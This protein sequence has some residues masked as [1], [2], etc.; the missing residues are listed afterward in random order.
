VITGRLRTGSE[1]L[2]LRLRV[3][4][5]ATNREKLSDFPYSISGL[6]TH[7]MG[8]KSCMKGGEIRLPTCVHCHVANSTLLWLLCQQSPAP[9]RRHRARRDRARRPRM[10]SHLSRALPGDCAPA[11]S[12]RG[13]FCGVPILPP[14]GGGEPHPAPAAVESVPRVC[15]HGRARHARAVLLALLRPFSRWRLLLPQQDPAPML[16][17]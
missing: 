16:G 12:D 10:S 5:G 7:S 11:K 2:S 13:R 9:G 14:V 15:I 6:R 1:I 4:Y 3:F 8:L 17:S